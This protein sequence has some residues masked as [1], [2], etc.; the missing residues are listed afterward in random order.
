MIPSPSNN[1]PTEDLRQLIASGVGRITAHQPD[2]AGRWLLV[3]VKAQLIYLL[4]DD[5]ETTNWPVSTAAAGLDNRQDSGGTPPGL[6][7]IHR[8]IGEGAES[9]MIFESREYT[10]IL[11]R[12]PAQGESDLA[13][14][15]DLI[16]TR[17]LTL[18]GQE[19]GF[20]R[21]P[22]VDSLERYIYIHGSNH[23]EAI[24]SPVS[25]GCVRM[26]N[27]DVLA[28]FDLVSEGDPVVII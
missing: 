21:G 12:R 14:D 4:E 6:H 28:L 16:L 3:D 19:D 9:A 7:L 24:G 10:G 11:W 8:K 18:D 25:G 2:F 23:E 27:Q 20:N 17:I 5:S 1:S 13:G 22:G 26:T 15:Q